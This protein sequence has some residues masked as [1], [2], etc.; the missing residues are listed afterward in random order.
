M[1]TGVSRFACK[2]NYFLLTS[3]KI[4]FQVSGFKFLLLQLLRLSENLKPE[5]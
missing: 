4:L 5:T 3:K 2:G 1:Y